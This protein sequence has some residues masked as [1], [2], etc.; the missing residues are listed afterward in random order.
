[1]V[2][3]ATCRGLNNQKHLKSSWWIIDENVAGVEAAEMA[4]TTAKVASCAL[5]VLAQL[6]VIALYASQSVYRC[7]GRIRSVS[8]AVS[9]V[10]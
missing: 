2:R 4:G 6:G 8:V 9:A 7:V 1:M 3:P 10:Q 5:E